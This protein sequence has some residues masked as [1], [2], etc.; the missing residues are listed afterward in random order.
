M[1]DCRWPSVVVVV[2]NY[3]VGKTNLSLNLAISARREGLDVTLVDL[4]V[5]NPYFRSSDYRKLLEDAGIHLIAPVFA[6]TNLDAPGI[7]GAIS[8]AIEMAQTALVHTR[9]LIIDAGGDD[10]GAAVLGR[11]AHSIKAGPYEML[12]VI[13]RCRS[14]DKEICHEVE[15]LHNIEAAAHLSATAVIN[16]THLQDETNAHVIAQGI[17]FASEVAKSLKLPLMCTTVKKELLQEVGVA[18]S[19]QAAKCTTATKGLLQTPFDRKN[20]CTEEIGLQHLFYP[21]G[22]YVHTP[23]QEENTN[24]PI[25]RREYK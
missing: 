5:V 10:A 16:N 1:R 13:N 7:S 8:V 17:S 11:F 4:D 23:W 21:V 19:G 6:G 2:G 15:I 22:V 3:G 14:L 25:T 20:V 12:Y 9:S 18:Q 24:R